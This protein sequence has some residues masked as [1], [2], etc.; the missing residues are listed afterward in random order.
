MHFDLKKKKK[1]KERKRNKITNNTLS[2]NPL[3][4]EYSS[5]IDTSFY[6]L[7]YFFFFWPV[8]SS[9]SSVLG[10]LPYTGSS[11]FRISL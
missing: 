7:M 11:S 4:Y 5:A 8:S 6:K 3:D 9:N 1:R 10:C 2:K